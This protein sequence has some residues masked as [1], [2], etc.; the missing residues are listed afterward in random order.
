M[1]AQ[2]QGRTQ[3][4]ASCLPVYQTVSS[5]LYARL[6]HSS[7]PGASLVLDAGAENGQCRSRRSYHRACGSVG[8]ILLRQRQALGV[9]LWTG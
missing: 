8:A 5:L 9:A 1:A 3:S 7:Q 2:S 4:D 6:G